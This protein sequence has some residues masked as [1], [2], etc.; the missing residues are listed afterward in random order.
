MKVY[1][2]FN[3]D[4]T[5]TKG[6]GRYQFQVG[7]KEICEG[8][9]TRNTGFHA[10]EYILE[11]LDWYPLDGK[12]R[13]CIC[14]AEGSVDEDGEDIIC[15]TEIT[16]VRE[17]KVIDIAFAAVEYMIDHPSRKW[18]RTGENLC[19]AKDKASVG[20]RGIAIARGKDPKVKGGKGSY[21]GLVKEDRYGD[22]DTVRMF[23]TGT[24][25]APDVWY[26]LDD[27]G[28]LVRAGK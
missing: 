1:K 4:L 3:S 24:S 7:R 13:Y 20:A 21:I 15:C 19:V 17:L 8:S 6:K 25:A 9:K 14:E 2:G 28:N 26:T 16:P 22:P 10:S 23:L 5:C 11:C 18:E 12:N 27:A